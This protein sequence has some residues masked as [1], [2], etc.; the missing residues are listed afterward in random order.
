MD[1]VTNFRS[2]VEKVFDTTSLDAVLDIQSDRVKPLA[3]A[4]P[5]QGS[6]FDCIWETES[7][8]KYGFRTI[9]Q[10]TLWKQQE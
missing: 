5:D 6:K 10:R 2:V 4:T 3:D 1:I 8:Y 7:L 9:F